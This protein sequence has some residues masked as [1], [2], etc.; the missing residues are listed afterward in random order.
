MK[1]WRSGPTRIKHLFPP[2]PPKVMGKEDWLEPPPPR[3][4]QAS[5]PKAE[6]PA[7]PKM[8]DFETM[9]ADYDRRK[10]QEAERIVKRA[11]E[12]ETAR[13]KGAEAIKAHVLPHARE[14]VSRLRQSGHRVVYQESLEH[15]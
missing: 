6:P 13:T 3:A 2:Q 11:L 10:Q 14:V 15:Y 9:L 12:I 1:V 5:A 4:A 7:P 8:D